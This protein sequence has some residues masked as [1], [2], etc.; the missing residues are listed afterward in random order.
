MK[1]TMKISDHCSLH[2]SHQLVLKD[3]GNTFKEWEIL[4]VD[5]NSCSVVLPAGWFMCV[6]AARAMLTELPCFFFSLPSNLNPMYMLLLSSAPSLR[7]G[8]SSALQSLAFIT[9]LSS[10]SKLQKYYLKL[11]FHLFSSRNWPG[12]T[13]RVRGRSYAD[14]NPNLDCFKLGRICSLKQIPLLPSKSEQKRKF[15][16]SQIRWQRNDF[17]GIQ[18]ACPLVRFVILMWGKKKLEGKCC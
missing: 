9:P 11:Y 2:C 15:L 6:L 17:S 7:I 3:T 10:L 8:P 5:Y 14:S 13:Q 16:E 1:G 4:K 12:V 18:N